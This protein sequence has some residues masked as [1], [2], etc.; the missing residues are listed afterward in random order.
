MRYPVASCIV[1]D[2]NDSMLDAGRMRVA[3]FLVMAGATAVAVKGV[4]LMATGNDRSLVPWF[5]LFTCLGFV[6]AASALWRSV[7]GLRW[8]AALGGLAALTGAA[9]AAVA[10]VYLITGT[11]PESDGAPSAV[12]ASYAVM[13][14][15]TFIALLILG[16]VIAANRSLSGWWRWVP[17]GV[18]G[19]QMPIF[20]VA[21][22]I[23]EGVGSE[24]VADGLS[25]ALTGAAWMLLGYALARPPPD[26]DSRP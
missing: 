8:L 1:P 25:L 16:I 21:G 3:G 19:V 26:P 7:Q 22:A 17:L 18:L 6:I 20:V 2:M 10:V 24:D 11:I 23:A 14:A 12:G 5:G 15:G 13:A 4:L 9:A